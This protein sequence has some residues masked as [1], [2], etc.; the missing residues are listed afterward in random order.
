MANI[1]CGTVYDLARAQLKDA[2]PLDKYEIR[3]VFSN[4]AA[5]F[6]IDVTKQY[7]ML[8][9]RELADYTVFNFLTLNYD[10]GKTELLEVVQ[11]RG[12]IL[13]VD[14]NHEQKYFEI[15]VRYNQDDE[16]HMYA[17]FPCNDF[18]IEV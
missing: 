9:C 2:E 13:R 3:N 4:I 11:S 17:F 18:V 5:W 10:K 14:Y 8:L 1:E 15:W 16:P 6:S 7:Y 12:D